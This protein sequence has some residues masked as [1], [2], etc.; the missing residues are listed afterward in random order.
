[1]ELIKYDLDSFGTGHVFE[2]LT[3][4]AKKQT[5]YQSIE[6]CELEYLGK[7]LVL[8]NIIQLSSLDCNRYHET[9]AHIPMSCLHN[10][11]RVLILG[12]GDGILAKELLKYDDVIVD[13]VDIDRQVCELSDIHLR[14]LNEGSLTDTRVNVY[15]IDALEFCGDTPRVYDVI[16]ADI[17]DPHPNSPSRS[18]LS[19]QAMGLYKSLLTEQGIF[20]AQV[21]NVQIAPKHRINVAKSLRYHFENVGEFAI[22]ALTL[23]GL[24]GFLWA[25]NTTKVVPNDITVPTNWLNKERFM[26]CFNLLRLALGDTNEK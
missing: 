22:A 15:N 9:F 1:M 25:S 10:P 26:F 19:K 2:R 24:F 6:I 7:V 23:S 5:T 3:M 12:G 18:L 4:Y 11:K 17:T 13:L 16:Y 20:V 8:D 21:D 14:D